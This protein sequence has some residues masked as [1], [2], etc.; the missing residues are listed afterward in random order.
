MI[1]IKGNEFKR[2]LKIFGLFIE[3]RDDVFKSPHKFR[4]NLYLL[5]D[6]T[7][8]IINRPSKCSSI[9]SSNILIN[10]NRFSIRT[11]KGK[12]IFSLLSQLMGNV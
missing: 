11:L 1:K 6:V 10:I 4:N 3:I 2:L 9:D 8:W 7:V 12:I 5:K